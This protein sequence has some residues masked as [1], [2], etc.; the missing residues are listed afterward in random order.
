MTPEQ[1]SLVQASFR[2]V[3]RIDETAARLFYDR[4]FTLDPSL[5][6]L[7]VGDMAEQG[8]R[9]M[10]LLAAA[11]GGLDDLETLLPTVRALG[12]RH[13]TYGVK[14]QHYATVGAALIWTLR[15]GLGDDFTEDV[16][17]AWIAA[18]TVL[19]SAMIDAAYGKVA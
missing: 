19:S 5:K 7:F 16:R 15:Q 12:V 6:G 18:Y 9:L 10:A 4:L 17:K 2:K 14:R 13:A 3:I 11:V 1:I 8:Q